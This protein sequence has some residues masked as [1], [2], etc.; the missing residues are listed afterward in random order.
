M[1]LNNSNSSLS[2]FLSIYCDAKVKVLVLED[3][4]AI[5]TTIVDP[6][7]AMDIRPHFAA[8]HAGRRSWLSAP[9]IYCDAPVICFLTAPRDAS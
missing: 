5:A 4:P 7:S 8:H 9:R 1:H 3:F 2:L 6:R